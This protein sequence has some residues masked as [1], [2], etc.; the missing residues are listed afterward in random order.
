MAALKRTRD[1]G[2]AVHPGQDIE[3]IVVDDGKT[4][5]ERVA[6]AHEEIGLYDVSYY[7][8]QLVRTVESVL[9]PPG[10]DRS[11]IRREL[12]ERSTGVDGVRGQGAI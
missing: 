12:G 7:G 6:L 5:L 3:Y 4:S 10:W 2:I 1:Q 8:T 11:N 9:S